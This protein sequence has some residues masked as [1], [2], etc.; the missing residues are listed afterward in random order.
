MLLDPCHTPLSR[1]LR[2]LFLIPFTLLFAVAAHTQSSAAG[3]ARYSPRTG[4][5]YRM[6]GGQFQGSSDNS[7]WITLYTITTAPSDAYT[8]AILTTDPR[9]FRYLRYLAPDGTCGNVA[10]I[11]FDSGTG[12]SAVK[13]T[14]TPF[15]TPGSY[16]NSGNDF[17]KV[18]DGNTSTF[19]DAP[20]PGNGDYVG[21][22]QGPP[23]SAQVGQVRYFPR[24]GYETRM[25]GGLFQGSSDNSTWTTFYT[26]TAPPSDV[27]TTGPLTVDPKTLRYLRYLSPDSG[28][29]NVAEIEFDS[30]TGSNAVKLTGTPF[31]TP[32]SYNNGG[33]DFTKVFDGST[34]TFFDAPYPGNGDF[35]GI[36][37]GVLSVPTA[38]MGLQATST[39]AFV[40]LTWQPVGSATSYNLYRT[41]SLTTA[42]IAIQSVSD[43]SSIDSTISLGQTYYYQV[44]ALN[45]V[46]ESPLSSPVSI[47]PTGNLNPVVKLTAPMSGLTLTAGTNLLLTAAAMPRSGTISKIDFYYAPAQYDGSGNPV[48]AAGTLIGTAPMAP[49]SLVWN[50]LPSGSFFLAAVATDSGG[51]TTTSAPVIVTVS[52]PISGTVLTSAQAI[53]IAQTFC[54]AIGA[55]IGT[56]MPTSATVNNAS[57]TYIGSVWQVNFQGAANVEVAD[58]TGIVISYFNYTL[59]NQLN[60][61]SQAPGTPITQAQ[62]QTVAATVLQASQQPAAELANQQFTQSSLLYPATYAGDL[63]TV[64]WNR[65]AAG[66]PYRSDQATLLL[67]AETGSVEAWKLSFPTPA[68]AST[69]STVTQSQAQQIA[70]AEMSSSGSY[71]ELTNQVFQIAQQAVVQPNT[72]WPSG[73]STTPGTPMPV[74]GSSSRVMWDCYFSNAPASGS[75]SGS[76]YSEVW[77]DAATG[78]IIGGNIVQVM[79]HSAS[80]AKLTS[81]VPRARA[82]HAFVKSMSQPHN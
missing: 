23:A 44:S 49:Y 15:G 33:N 22:D 42:P 20:S 34:G 2:L 32:G 50:N 61:N 37:Q 68:V 71:L 66:I 82:S 39:D 14:G 5:G 19:F 74:P 72:L 67:Q 18:F 24:T 30:G 69:A 41:S 77:V 12:T 79:G 17:T 4:F 9:T 26:I 73:G 7:T 60:A 54:R 58:A 56:G 27:Y 31:G 59:A 76:T 21:I 45:A 75:L 47:M 65:A 43:S 81:L 80:K 6:V 1:R 35:V 53:Q 46:G 38:P 51:H 57:P 13:L 48:V 25:V 16:N 70:Q 64:R 52:A 10:E 63:W 78:Q 3:Q 55:P 40:S 28:C 62:A 11:E 29:G 36:D 8:T